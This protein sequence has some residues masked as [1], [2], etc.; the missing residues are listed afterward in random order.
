LS[1]TAHDPQASGHP[2]RSGC[3]C[4]SRYQNKRERREDDSDR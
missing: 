4:D 2:G 3:A 1:I